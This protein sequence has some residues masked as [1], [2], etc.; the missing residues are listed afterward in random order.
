MAYS[1]TFSTDDAEQAQ[2]MLTWLQ[3]SKTV[4]T[5][6]NSAINSDHISP[7][8]AVVAAPV[9]PPVAAP[10]PV[11][12]PAA[13]PAPVAPPA[14]D[15]IH[16]DDKAVLD[17]GW[18]MDHVKQAATNYTSK[19]GAAGAAGLKKLLAEFGAEKI[20]VSGK[21]GPNCLLPRHYPAVVEKLNG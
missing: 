14:A 15:A 20:A 9:A 5:L 18:T 12:P 19:L 10:A 8:L 6:E 17:L 3:K 7:T 1:F 11:A 4:G 21:V 2:A 16:P 13:A